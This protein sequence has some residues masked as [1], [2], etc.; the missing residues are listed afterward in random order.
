MKNK[1]DLILKSIFDMYP[2]ME[3]LLENNSFSKIDFE[4]KAVYIYPNA[5]ITLLEKHIEHINNDIL[6]DYPIKLEIRNSTKNNLQ[7]D[8]NNRINVKLKEN[9][10]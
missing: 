2:E 9:E 4:K 1:Q 3:T 7:Y 5:F 8:V 6:K 10:K